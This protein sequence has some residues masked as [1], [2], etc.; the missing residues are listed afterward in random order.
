MLPAAPD[1]EFAAGDGDQPA[2]DE[3]PEPAEHATVGYVT[4]EERKVIP[5][6]SNCTETI[7]ALIPCTH[8]L[9]PD[10]TV[11]LLHLPLPLVSVSIGTERGCQ[12]NDR[13]V[14]G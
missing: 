2:K 8:P 3:Q 12:Q 10:E 7:A 9:A 5:V 1:Q 6:H 13:L 4:P 14:R 11:I